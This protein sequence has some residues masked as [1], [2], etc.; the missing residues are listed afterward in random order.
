MNEELADL[1]PS[2]SEG[3]ALLEEFG[4]HLKD[5]QPQLNAIE[6]KMEKTNEIIG[7]G[8]EAQVEGLY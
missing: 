8:I 1:V 2:M 7:E 5:Q 3:V 4:F 6:L